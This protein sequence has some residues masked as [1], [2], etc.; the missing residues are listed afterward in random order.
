[1]ALFE[2]KLDRKLS[3]YQDSFKDPVENE[4][5]EELIDHY[6][7]RILKEANLEHLTS[8]P[9]GEMKLRIEQLLSHFMSEEKIILPRHEKEELLTRIIDESI[10]YGPLE[11]L[12][13]DQT[14]TEILI[15]GHK[16]IYVEKL[17]KL[18][19]VSAQFKDENH[20]RHVVDRIVSPIGR[21]ID[22]SS[23]MVDA[24]LPDGSRVNAV[25]PPISLNGTL[26]SIR[27]FRKDPF[28]MKDLLNLGTLNEELSHFLD[29]CVKSK[30]NILISGGTGSGKTTLL[31]V[32]GN[33]IPAGER[34]I[35]IEDSA[36]LRINKPN[37][38]G[39]E[40]R[41]ENVEGKGEITIRHL[42]R[43]A[44][45]MRP[46]RIIVGE[47]RGAEAFDMLQ[48]M[49]TG[50]EGS[51]TTVHANTPFDA[52]RRV[53]GMVIMAGM[54]LPS[55]V[56]REYIVG[57]LDIIVQSSRLTDGTRKLTSV[58]EVYRSET[59]EIEI[60]EIFTFNRTGLTKDGQVEG[61]FKATG[62]IPKC[63]ERMRVFGIN[64]PLEMFTA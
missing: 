63:I 36:E 59:G 53:E 14:I 46:D 60:K 57:A 18:Q 16:E 51:I 33:S 3:L 21:R 28:T 41:P 37:V 5:L 43:N 30:L 1:M 56:I 19:R 15:N 39:M 12:L 32:L 7:T 8:L 45:R 54:E 4:R 62:Y 42:V 22:E 29:A 48:A 6:K 31:N 34:I 58:C 20:L 25:I 24:R 10:G 26:V 17:G 49:N 55:S 44:L 13:D 61:S 64:L 23:P 47:V 35:T 27:K 9:Q 50:H 2:K 40:A 38:V 11:P 52:I